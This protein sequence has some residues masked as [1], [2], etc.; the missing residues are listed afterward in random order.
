MSGG[1]SFSPD[2]DADLHKHRLKQ[3]CLLA[4]RHSLNDPNFGSAIVLLCRHGSEGAYGLILNHPSHMPLT[5]LFDHPPE[6]ALS[7]GKNRRIYMGGPVQ[8][9]ELQILQVG[10]EFAPGSFE[11]AEGVHLGGAWSELE[12]IP[13]WNP[14]NLRLFLGYSGWG[15]GQLEREVE[16]GAWEVFETDLSKLLLGP[17]EPWFGGSDD[18]KRFLNSR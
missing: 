11:V 16:Q 14:K 9:V 2:F 13:S 8:S 15:E 6:K 12:E 5:E 3:G 4:A 17:E 10:M 1:E 7:F 18:F